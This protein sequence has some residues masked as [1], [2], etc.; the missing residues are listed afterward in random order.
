MPFTTGANVF[1]QEKCD[2]TRLPAFCAAGLLLFCN[3]SSPAQAH[4]QSSS[5]LTLDVVERVP[6]ALTIQMTLLDLLH[7][8]D[9]DGN[10]DGKLTW[11]EVSASEPEVL[12]LIASNVSLRA[13]GS[14][15]ELSA[16]QRA[17]SL[18]THAEEPALRVALQVHCPEAAEASSFLLSFQLFFDDD[19][20]HKALLTVSGDA[21]DETYLL[22]SDN[23]ELRW[24]ALRMGTNGDTP[25]SPLLGVS[26]F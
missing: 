3:G 7:L 25:K 8:V 21:G 2:V 17:F 22:T 12:K 14:F 24:P 6:Q 1:E 20:T 13:G 4:S 10:G 11:G 26:P 16:K 9:L 19:P 5:R 18:T 23:R 15:C